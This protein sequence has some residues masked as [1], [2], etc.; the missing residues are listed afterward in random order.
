MDQ[1]M[2]STLGVSSDEDKYDEEWV[3]VVNKV[4]Y[5]LSKNQ[6]LLVKQAMATGER[7]TIVF[8]SFVIAI[9]YVSEF[10]R[11]RRFLKDTYKLP[12]KA[13]EE[14]FVP[15]SDEQMAKFR[16]KA[17]DAIGKKIPKK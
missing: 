3:A 7:G 12:A 4:N 1:K 13:T 2:G 14:E 9:P 11:K 16:K 15:L 5:P 10:Y 6:A 17:Y 8:D